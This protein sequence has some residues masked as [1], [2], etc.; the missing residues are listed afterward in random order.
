[1]KKIFST[2]PSHRTLLNQVTCQLVFLSQFLL[3]A[4]KQNEMHVFGDCVFFSSPSF[5]HIAT[6]LLDEF[7][8]EFC[9]QNFPKHNLSI[10]NFP[11]IRVDRRRSIQSN[12]IP[13]QSAILNDL[14]QLDWE[15]EDIDNS[16]N[17][18]VQ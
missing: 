10:P 11:S 9:N 1:M 13:L 15:F 12:D 18:H 16:L 3:L 4:R 5:I 6:D 14:L 7:E 17:R 8:D 2:F